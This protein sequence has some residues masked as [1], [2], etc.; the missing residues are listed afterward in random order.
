MSEIFPIYKLCC[1]ENEQNRVIH[2][3][4]M[5]YE[6]I[7]FNCKVLMIYKHNVIRTGQPKD[8]ILVYCKIKI[9]QYRDWKI[10]GCLTFYKYEPIFLN[11]TNIQSLHLIKIKC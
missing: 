10:F 9:S 1:I 6:H 11:W 8:N 4:V 3:K 2:I 5:D 7:V